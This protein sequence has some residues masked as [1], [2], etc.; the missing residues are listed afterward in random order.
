MH[1]RH[2]G[3]IGAQTAR[4]RR[5]FMLVNRLHR[6]DA[7]LREQQNAIGP[8]DKANEPGSPRADSADEERKAQ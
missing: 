4:N 7:E 2:H 5:L 1:S 6:A 3:A 8:G